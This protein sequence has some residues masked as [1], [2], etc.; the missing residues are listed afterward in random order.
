MSGF[1]TESDILSTDDSDE[2][3]VVAK[4]P[5]NAKAGHKLKRE[6]GKAEWLS[7]S[8]PLTSFDGSLPTNKRKAEWVRYRDQFERITSCK[9]P[10]DA[11]TKLTGLKIFAE[12]YLLSIIEMQQKSVP[13]SVEDV[14]QATIAALNCFLNQTCDAS[15]ERMK[16]RDMKM[17]ITEAFSDWVLRLENQA[18]FCDFDHGQREEEFIQALVRRSVMGIREKLFEMSD[19]LSNDLKR[20]INHG[21][22]LDYIR[23]EINE[24]KKF[25]EEDEGTN[26]PEP[27]ASS[28]TLIKP[29]NALYFRKFERRNTRDDGSR[30]TPR[31]VLSHINW[32]HVTVEGALGSSQSRVVKT[33]VICMARVHARL[34]V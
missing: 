22:H 28:A 29:V 8:W 11:A 5:R 7:G 34:I 17:R 26:D 9:P 33:V 31:G 20:I 15:K 19:F 4:P 12:D 24:A 32:T 18:K 10:V 14:Y 2:P 25:K 23:S 27:D 16:F 1:W 6:R 30:R 13:D 3:N 21:K